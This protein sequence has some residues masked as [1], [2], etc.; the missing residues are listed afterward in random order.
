MNLKWK[1]QILRIA[2]SIAYEA[3]QKLRKRSHSSK[4]IHT[5]DIHDVKI[6][7]DLEAERKI[8][9]GLCKNFDFP[10]LSEESGEM[11]ES[12]FARSD[13]EFKWIVDP[14]DGSLNYAKGIPFCGISIGLWNAENAVLG[15]VYD[16]FRDDLYS[17][18]VES[19][20]WKNRKKIR[21]SALNLKSE[22]VLCTGIPIKDN[23]SKKNLSSFVSGF[24]HYK[25]V[26]LLG[27]ASLSLCMVASGAAEV[28]QENNIQLWDVAGGIPIVLAAGGK[29]ERR[30]TSAGEFTYN[31]LASNGLI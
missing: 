7:A 25:K 4:L 16:I 5:S 23:F 20:A 13:T 18:I 26:R 12:I 2:E 28:Y 27:S 1:T 6:G 22:S 21:V 30:K 17:G 24:Q 15:V 14:L 31:V 8:I 29:V 9:K 11:S 10:I 3:G 19:A